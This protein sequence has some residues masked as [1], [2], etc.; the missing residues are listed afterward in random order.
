M[1]AKRIDPHVLFSGENSL[2]AEDR[3]RETVTLNGLFSYEPVLSPE[4]PGV[5]V[6]RDRIPWGFELRHLWA[7]NH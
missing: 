1:F 4:E 2:V 3:M 7:Q 6:F 5:Q